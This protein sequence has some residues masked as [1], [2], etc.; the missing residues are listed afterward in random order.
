MQHRL[1]VVLSAVLAVSGC[2]VGGPGGGGPPPQIASPSRPAVDGQWIGTD[3]VAIST[4]DQGKFTS[5]LAASGEPLTEGSYS[6]ESNGLIKI[7]FYSVR[8]QKDVA[9]NCLIAEGTRLNCTLD[10]GT[11]FTLVRKGVA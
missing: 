4:F 3:G 1:W 10:N 8:A 9:A 7:Q 5:V 11:Q 6:V 2:Q